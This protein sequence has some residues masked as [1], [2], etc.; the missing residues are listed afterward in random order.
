MQT[1]KGA[2]TVLA[3]VGNH[4][5]ALLLALVGRPMDSKMRFAI[6][7]S[8][9][10]VNTRIDW[11]HSHR[12]CLSGSCR[13]GLHCNNGLA[14]EKSTQVAFIEHDHMVNELALA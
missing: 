5:R 2:S 10:A 13:P 8:V 7:G 4:H 12:R 1:G 3:R 14:S 6:V 9:I 11:P